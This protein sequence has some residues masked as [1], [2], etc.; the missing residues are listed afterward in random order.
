MT[1]IEQRV[2]LPEVPVFDLAVH[3]G[4][5][6]F[7]SADIARTGHWE[8]LET[9]IVCGLLPHYR[10]FIDLGAN[11]GWYTVIAGLLLKGRGEVHAFEP[12]AANFRLL[13]HNVDL[14]GLDNVRLHQIA[15]G[16]R[17]G[18]TE[19]FLAADNQGDHSLHGS[20]EQRPSESVLLTTLDAHFG[21]APPGPFLLKADTQGAEPA[22]LAG[23]RQLL[24]CSSA[25][26]AFI[27]EFWPF[28]IVAAGW[29]VAGY[30]DAIEE[31]EREVYV[32]DETAG[33]LWRSSVT[34]LA[35]AVG[36][37]LRPEGRAFRNIALLPP[38]LA[39]DAQIE[40]LVRG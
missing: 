16:S 39:Q 6:H 29:T 21:A 11:I 5:D 17:K 13:R 35:D 28:G 33:C 4:A 36:G 24:R 7:I 18:T 2:T 20:G 30:L 15:M 9:R 19:L 40:A 12:A 14:N 25:A 38:A 26:S 27:L 10:L 32:L 3:D 8:P 37:D 23:S 34:G 1:W 31:L 22:I